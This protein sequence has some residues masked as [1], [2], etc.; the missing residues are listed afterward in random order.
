MITALTRREIAG[1]QHS[2]LSSSAWMWMVISPPL[3]LAKH[4]SAFGALG[5][6]TIAA[7]AMHWFGPRVC[8]RLRPDFADGI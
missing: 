8:M 4:L 3:M 2:P 6:F 5:A 1:H 7:L